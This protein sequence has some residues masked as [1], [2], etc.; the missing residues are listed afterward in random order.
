MQARGAPDRADARLRRPANFGAKTPLSPASMWQRI[1]YQ[2]FE[3][4]LGDE[5]EQGARGMSS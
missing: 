5:H 1:C 4:R 2:V 3:S